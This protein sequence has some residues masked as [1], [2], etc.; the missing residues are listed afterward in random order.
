MN[1]VLPH[2]GDI[3]YME[4]GNVG[5]FYKDQKINIDNF[6]INRIV[7][8]A[9]EPSKSFP[10]YRYLI[11]NTIIQQSTRLNCR[12]ASLLPDIPHLEIILHLLFYPFVVL[13]PDK[14]L[15]R[16]DGINLKKKSKVKIN[17]ELTDEEIIEANLIRSVIK[18]LF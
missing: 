17:Y 18:E 16:Y 15:T 13:L 14:K 7:G 9:P 1:Q 12:Y 5:E 6:S 4:E 10:S 11:T 8:V 2:L 3:D